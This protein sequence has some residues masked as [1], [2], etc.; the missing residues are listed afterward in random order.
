[1]I[2]DTLTVPVLAVLVAIV[3]ISAAAYLLWRRRSSAE[4]VEMTAA[5]KS[6]RLAFQ[7]Q[8]RPVPAVPPKSIPQPVQKTVPLPQPKEISLLNGRSDISESLTA[9]TEKYSLDGFTIATADGLIFATGGGDGAQTDAARYSEAFARSPVPETPGVVLRGLA[10]KGS[11]LILILRT[12]AV[13]P[14]TL[15]TGIENDTK[16]ILNWWI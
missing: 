15:I 6:K 10:F 5:Q 2:S 14:D 4:P 12:Q 3:L 11:D 8:A 9:L 13:I 1:M 16:D 7:P